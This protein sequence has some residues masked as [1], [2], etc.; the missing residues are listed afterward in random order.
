MPGSGKSTLARGMAKALGKSV[1]DTD[2]EFVRRYGPIEAFWAAYG[3]ER[4][5]KTEQELYIECAHSDK[6]II[7]CGGGAVLS[8][9]AMNAL[10]AAGDIVYLTA[11]T[12]LLKSRT[13]GSA[14]PLKDD[15][16][17]LAKARKPLYEMYA[18]YTVDASCGDVVK[19]TSDALSENRP[20]RYDVILC[21]A[22]DTVL[23]FQ[24][25]MEYAVL[26]TKAACA[27][28]SDD[29]SLIGAFRKCTDEVFKRLER[30]E[31]DR[32]TLGITRFKMVGEMLG[33]EIDG[34]L[35]HRTFFEEMKKTRFVRAGAIEFLDDVRARGIKVY[36]A[37]NSYSSIAE[38]RLKVLNGHVDGAFVSEDVGF[39]KPNVKYFESVY[40]RIGRPNKQ[41][42]LMLGD[43]NT[44]DVAG[45]IAFGIDTCFFDPTGRKQTSADYRAG[46]YAEVLKLI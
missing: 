10:R 14:R 17:G 20:N 37:T 12:E 29:K 16:E 30:G 39:D 38:K 6:E 46:G 34:E 8:K 4:F 31:I 5:R 43:S 26:N 24:A 18:D 42:M 19:K 3:E 40:N 2:E 9:P 23:D 27:I 41:R 7:S 22:D 15:I 45:G 11:P 35:A 32:G 1:V 36:I 25:A 13:E 21:D 33:E 44:S 28:K